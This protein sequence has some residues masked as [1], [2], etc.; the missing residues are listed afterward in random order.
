LIRL[1]A[2]ET[3]EE[4]QLAEVRLQEDWYIGKV[5]WFQCRASTLALFQKL[6]ALANSNVLSA[7]DQVAEEIERIGFVVDGM[8]EVRRACKELQIMNEDDIA[9]KVARH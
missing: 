8:F 7:V 2:P 6:E 3:G 4:I 5:V 9:F 1:F